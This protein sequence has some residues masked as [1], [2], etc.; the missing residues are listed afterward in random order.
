METR[1]LWQI[2]KNIYTNKYQKEHCKQF[3]VVFPKEEM[4][5]LESLIKEKGWTKAY[6]VRWAFEQLKKTK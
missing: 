3:K 6:F 5:E 2:N 1:K 4:E